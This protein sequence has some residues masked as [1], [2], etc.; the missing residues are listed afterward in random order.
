M[1]LNTTGAIS[2]AGAT[3]GQ[4]IALELGLGTATQI[5][6]ND[7]AV[8]TL[9]GVL[10]GAITMPTNFWGKSNIT[11]YTYTVNSS[12]TIPSGKTSMSIKCWGGAGAGNLFAGALFGG[13]GGGFAGATI[14]VSAG[15]SYVIAVGGGGLGANPAVATGTG[16]TN[17]GGTGRCSTAGTF[18]SHFGGGGYSGVFLTSASQANARVIAG[19]GGAAGTSA[20]K[21]GAGGGNT[22]QNG[23]PST[24]GTR[25]ALGGTQTAGG[26]KGSGTST[27]GSALQGGNGGASND[28]LGG[29]GG[30]G[31][32]WG[33]GGCGWGPGGGGGSGFVSGTLTTNTQGNLTAVANSANVDYVAG[34]GNGAASTNGQPGY[35][36]IYM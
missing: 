24:G 12:L 17:G 26:V 10:S 15:Q 35:V 32:Y 18:A 27:N 30:G 20:Y 34:K 11:K 5:S 28:S 9:A 2:L 7:T 3:A 31:G 13:G 21:P 29:S 36:V 25:S 6:L 1:A 23:A 8:R 33:G 16:G 22:G 4:S 19:G 14:T